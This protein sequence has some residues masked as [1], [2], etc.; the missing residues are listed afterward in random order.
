[1]SENYSRRQWLKSTLSLGGVVAGA[2]VSSSAQAFTDACLITP[3][4]TEGPF[5]PI[6]DQADKDNDLTAVKGKTVKAKGEI[7]Y[8][9]GQVLDEKCNPVP[10]ALVEIWQACESGR[11]N[12]PG[13]PNTTAKLDPNFQYWGKALTDSEGRY[14]FKTIRPGAYPASSSWWRPPHIHYKVTAFGFHGLTTQLYFAGEALNDKDHILLGLEP[15][16][17][18]RVVIALVDAGTGETKAMKGVFD[19]TLRRVQG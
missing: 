10:K 6:K 13:D 12:H 9:S 18:E 2:V 8:I 16:E 3:P 19:L 1:M 11:Y 7:V 17:R 4:Q 15:A 14:E 5:Y